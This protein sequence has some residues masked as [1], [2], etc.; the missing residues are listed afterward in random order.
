MMEIKDTRVYDLEESIVAS[1]FPMNTSELYNDFDKQFDIIKFNKHKKRAIKLANTSSSS[2]HCNFLSGILVSFNIKYPQYF[3]MQLQRYHFVQIVSSASKM[4]RLTNMGM[5]KEGETL[6]D[7]KI[8]NICNAM[9]KEY[10]STEHTGEKKE[11]FEEL[12]N[13]LPMG[14]QLWMR[15]TTNYLQLKTIYKQRRN[16]KLEEW[17]Q[18]CEWIETLPLSELIIA[19][20]YKK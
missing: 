10:N 5:P 14:F 11:I 17:Q 16:H 19:D 8:L 1:G 12:I 6:I 20:K 18:F 7:S 4:H 3:A 9:I 15:C 13:S 2:G